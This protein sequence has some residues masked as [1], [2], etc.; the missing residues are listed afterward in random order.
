[1]GS[2]NSFTNFTDAVSDV[3]RRQ[4]LVD[5]LEFESFKLDNHV[6]ASD[7][8]T[9]RER[10]IQLHHVH[11]PKL[12][13]YEF[14]EWNTET[15]EVSKGPLFEEYQPVLEAIHRRQSELPAGYLPRGRQNND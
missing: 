11:L 8:T 5:L 12:E 6:Y 2:Q 10:V 1:M 4:I 3:H 9:R 7:T 13:D 14:I 15:G